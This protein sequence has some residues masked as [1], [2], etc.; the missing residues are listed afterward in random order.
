MGKTPANKT[1]KTPANK[2]GKTP[3]NKTA[4]TPANKT[5]KTPTAKKS[6][7][8]MKVRFNEMAQT[9]S[10]NDEPMA[11]ADNKNSAKLGINPTPPSRTHWFDPSEIPVLFGNADE[12]AA[13][14]NEAH[15]NEE[16]HR[17][18]GNIMGQYARSPVV[19]ENTNA[20]AIRVAKKVKL[21][22]ETV[23]R[24]KSARNSNKV[25]KGVLKR[26]QTKKRK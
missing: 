16:I 19:A 4:K 3:A 25:G 17:V 24:L 2:T 15:E 26:R 1:G 9:T 5:G 11:L 8:K 20:N 14:E 22:Q 6:G 12:Y 18:S 10:P 13:S 21:F 23:K 7:A